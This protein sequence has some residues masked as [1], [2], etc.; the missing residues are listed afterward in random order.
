[1]RKSLERAHSF[2][3]AQKT[4]VPDQRLFFLIGNQDYSIRREAEGYDGFVDLPAVIEDIQN[5]RDGLIDLGISSD[6]IIEIYDAD[7]TTI[8]RD[9]IQFAEGN[10]SANWL[11]GKQKTMIFVYYAGHGIMS[12]FTKAVCNS[13]DQRNRVSYPLESNLRVLGTKP[14]AFVMGVFD[15]CRASFVEPESKRG[16]SS[17]DNN[18]N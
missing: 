1:M 16:I 5:A 11:N 2:Q 14:G 6:A 17:E 12:N 13:P 15:C 7:F 8:S 10:I 3:K 18:V 9:V 4:F